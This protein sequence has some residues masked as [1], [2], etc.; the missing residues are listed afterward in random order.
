MTIKCLLNQNDVTHMDT[1]SPG[2]SCNVLSAIWVNVSCQ[3]H[4]NKL[5]STCQEALGKTQDTLEWLW[6]SAVWEHLWILPEELE[7]VSREREVWMDGCR[8]GNK[9]FKFESLNFDWDVGGK[10]NIIRIVCWLYVVAWV[11]VLTH[12][13]YWTYFIITRR[14]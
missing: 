3:A 7:E 14:S 11:F 13:R 9:I 10:D 12:F 6:H 2:L 5:Q 8:Y 4:W 1:W